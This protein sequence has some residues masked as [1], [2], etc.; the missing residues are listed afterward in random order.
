[1]PAGKYYIPI[2]V[3]YEAETQA[4]TPVN[5]MVVELDYSSKTLYVD[6]NGDNA[7]YPKYYR[8]MEARLKREQ[9][10]L[11][12]RKQGSKNREKQRLKVAKLHEKVAN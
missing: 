11:S 4:I 10:K 7:D 1:M 9:R 3:E 6:S 2:L 8:K 12:K 5:E